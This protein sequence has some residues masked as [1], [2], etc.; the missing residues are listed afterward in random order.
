MVSHWLQ[1]S[2]KAVKGWPTRYNSAQ[3][4][5]AAANERCNKCY[6]RIIPCI[7]YTH[8]QLNLPFF[9]LSTTFPSTYTHEH[10]THLSHY[11]VKAYNR[12]IFFFHTQHQFIKGRREAKMKKEEKKNVKNSQAN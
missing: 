1:L 3:D 6:H 4:S 5:F 9:S 2:G 10:E 12:D 8:I 11:V 7:P